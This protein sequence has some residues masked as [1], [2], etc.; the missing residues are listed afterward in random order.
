M[1][2]FERV[3]KRYP[4]GRDALS[5]VSFEIAAGEMAFLTGRTGAGKSTVLGL[6][7]LFER[8]SRG[9]VWV[10]GQNTAKLSS[11]R[12]PRLRRG[13]GIVFQDHR[14]LRE[15]PVFDNV[16]L[17]LMVANV[18][19]RE[20]GKRVRAALDQVGLLGHE[21]ALAHELSVGE[22]QR[23]GIARAIVSHPPLLIA[24]EPTGNLDAALAGEM[25]GLFR[26]IQQT[27]AT[28]LIATHDVALVRASGCRELSLRDGLLAGAPGAE[29]AEPLP[30]I[31]AVR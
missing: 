9:Q 23:V 12:I 1:I 29:G 5:D 11:R 27:G 10:N 14:L 25:I 26:R 2:R 13:I 30:V 17:P 31:V 4:N 22:Q 20:V 18:S 16:A 28:V 3:N 7:A 8:P 6:I 19:L 24:D 15:R 21:R